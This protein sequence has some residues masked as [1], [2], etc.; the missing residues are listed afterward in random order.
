M[1][2]TLDQRKLYFIDK[3]TDSFFFDHKIG[4]RKF[5]G[6]FFIII[7]KKWLDFSRKNTFINNWFSSHCIAIC[8]SAEFFSIF[9]GS[10]IQFS[11]RM[12]ELPIDLLVKEI[13]GKD[14][15]VTENNVRHYFTR[16]KILKKS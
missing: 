9:Q 6:E 11:G 10:K 2:I 12:G 16:K 13:E 15:D 4:V 5:L 3:Q 8:S 14:L 1:R 7:D